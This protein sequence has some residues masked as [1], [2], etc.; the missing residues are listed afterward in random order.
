MVAGDE[1]LQV[2]AVGSR[3]TGVS[4]ERGEARD[5]LVGEERGEVEP[6]L[7]EVRA[8]SG[9]AFQGRVIGDVF[10]IPQ[11]FWVPSLPPVQAPS[12]KPVISV[13]PEPFH[14]KTWISEMPPPFVS[15]L[16]EDVANL[17]VAA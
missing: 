6:T 5:R 1:V 7:E 2:G 17:M 10:A 12:A 14:L 15:E 9:K 11:A 8:P 16:D 3:R 4:E 13:I